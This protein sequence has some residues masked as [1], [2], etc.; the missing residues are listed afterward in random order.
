MSMNAEF[1]EAQEEKARREAEDEAMGRG[2]S[3]TTRKKR[4]ANTGVA[5][6]AAE[7]T[8]Q[9]LQVRLPAISAAVDARLLALLGLPRQHLWYMSCASLRLSAVLLLLAFLVCRDSISL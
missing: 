9:A 8:L 4:K 2:T 6:S 3:S 5:G 7:A 1:L